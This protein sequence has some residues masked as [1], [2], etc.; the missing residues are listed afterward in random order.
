[1]HIEHGRWGVGG[2]YTAWHGQVWGKTWVQVRNPGY[3]AVGLHS[4]PTLE[5][6]APSTEPSI[7]LHTHTPCLWTRR[8]HDPQYV[9]ITTSST[10][11][12]QTSP[13][14]NLR[15]LPLTPTW[16]FSSKARFSSFSRRNSRLRSCGGGGELRDG[17]VR[18]CM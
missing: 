15:A 3:W 17:Y 4:A 5:V 12:V 2:G 7:P 11:C 10:L 6:T 1:M 14:F 13:S 18:V 16:I 9:T 8:S